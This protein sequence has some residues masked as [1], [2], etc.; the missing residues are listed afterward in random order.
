MKKQPKA[1]S[2]R[3]KSITAH[4]SPS[5]RVALYARSALLPREFK[6]EAGLLLPF[7]TYFQDPFVGK[8]DPQTNLNEETKVPWEPGFADGPTS[9]RFAIVD[10]NADTGALQPPAVWNEPS[11]AFLGVKGQKL[12]KD[13]VDT[14]QFHQVSVWALLQC[15]LAFYEDP[16]AL[17]R[18]IPWA[19][20]GN[21][22]IVV[23]HAGFGENA[24]YDRDSKSLQFYYFDSDGETVY[25]CL[26]SDIVHH[27]FGHAV[28]DGVRP[29]FNESSDPQT[30]AFHEFMGDL[31]AILLT[32]KN[33]TLRQ[34]LAKTAD[35]KFTKAK[36]LFQVAEQFGQ[37]VDGHPY[38]RSA[39]NDKKMGDVSNE[40]HD[41][42]EVMTGAMFDVLKEL[43]E[44]YDDDVEDGSGTGA[45]AAGDGP[46]G[47][48]KGGKKK[49]SVQVFYA[50]ADRMQRM[51][52]QPLDLLPPVEVTFRDYALAVC[53]SQRLADPLDPRDYYG[54]LTDVF[55]KRKIFTA[56]DV[57]EL[58][59][60]T[61]LNDRLDL[62]VGPHMDSLS[63]SRA[64]AY[65]FLDDNREYLLIPASRDFFVSDQY[66][67][68]KRG[69]QNLMMPRQIVLQ[70]AW[71]EEVELSGA[72]FGKYDGKT[73][74]MLCGGTLVFDDNG[75]VL[76]WMMK[77]GSEA[78]GRPVGRGKRTERWAA[79]GK[80][81]TARRSAFLQNLADQIL[82]GEVGVALET[83]KGFIGASVPLVIADEDGDGNRIR[84][85]WAPHL[86][87]SKDD[88]LT[89][90]KTGERKWEISC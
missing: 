13:A 37:A 50:A 12:N 38:L 79:A 47:E 73:T 83:A 70:Y 74:S 54:M 88:Q 27:E 25:T 7:T 16:S 48:K 65:R 64:A 28:L 85:R 2:K 17:G 31:S 40:V 44:L 41:L 57:K 42:S 75:T 26:S 58:K 10:Y 81:G 68:R 39:F 52:I 46:S 19:F 66:E 36:T 32:L 3:R 61:Y 90:T 56:E 14:F 60:P 1:S 82:E 59:K 43:G 8:N 23:P 71:R 15:A 86:H 29:L 51:A 76:S 6:E 55:L 63:R 80:E 30:G 18:S 35:G 72:Q 62:A 34:Q 21:R 49:S 20:D 45:A 24:F 9:S 11:Q 67:A 87:L 77:P 84:F 78:Y 22:L 53:R 4:I 5:T 69:R 89:R 33:R